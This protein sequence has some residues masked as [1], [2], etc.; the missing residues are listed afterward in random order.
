M[1]ELVEKMVNLIAWLRLSSIVSRETLEQIYDEVEDRMQSLIIETLDR[2]RQTGKVTITGDG[3]STRFEVDVPNNLDT[4]E[5]ACYIS[6]TEPLSAVPSYAYARL[7]DKDN[8]GFHETIR[9]AIRFDNAPADG[10]Q[11]KVF[12]V[13]VKISESTQ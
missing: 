7:V 12:Y 10:E 6:S 8:D 5:L 4:D 11:V 9:L 13:C 2:I 3:S 1:N